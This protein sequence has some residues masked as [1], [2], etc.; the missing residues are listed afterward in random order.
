AVI[1]AGDARDEERRHRHLQPAVAGVLAERDAER[2]G[3]DPSFELGDPPTLSLR[4]PVDGVLKPLN[5]LLQML[6]ARVQRKRFILG[7]SLSRCRSRHVGGASDLS[8]PRD[9]ARWLTHCLAP[10][11][12]DVTETRAAESGGAPLL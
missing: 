2:C 6:D 5:E 8:D 1:S 11:P 9:Q 4:L 12:D 7:G 10:S 3:L